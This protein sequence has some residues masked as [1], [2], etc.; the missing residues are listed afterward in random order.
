MRRPPTI[1]LAGPILGCT[2]EET[3]GWRQG[4][5]VASHGAAS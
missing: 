1:Y 3:N 2:D 4:F 5:M